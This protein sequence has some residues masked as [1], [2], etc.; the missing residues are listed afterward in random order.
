MKA[1]EQVINRLKYIQDKLLLGCKNMG[2]HEY[3]E[4]QMGVYIVT[5]WTVSEY[6]P[7]FGKAYNRLTGIKVKLPEDVGTTWVG[8]QT[9]LLDI[10]IERAER[11]R[12]NYIR[13]FNDLKKYGFEITKNIDK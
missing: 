2:S 13:V 8:V 7:L 11:D 5:G 12:N 1:T 3:P 6:K 10:F 9:V 4:L